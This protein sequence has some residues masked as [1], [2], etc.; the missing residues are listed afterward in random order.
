MPRRVYWFVMVGGL[1]VALYLA[2]CAFFYV[3]QRDL[4]YFPQPASVPGERLQLRSHDGLKLVVSVAGP[5]E[6]SSAVLY[7]GGNA[8]DVSATASGLS[9]ILPGQRIYLMHYRGYGESEGQPTESGLRADAIALFDG[10]RAQHAVLSVAGRSLGS[11]VAVWL[12]T[13]RPVH[14][15]ALITPYDSIEQTAAHHYP[16]LPIAW[17]LKDRFDSAAIAGGITVPT[18][19]L[20]AQQDQVIPPARTEALMAR[21]KPTVVTV[22]RFDGR[23]HGDISLDAKYPGA[24]ARALSP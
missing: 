13:Q 21:F 18:S 19:V 8:E 16:F 11:G 5:V 10:V 4:L 1:L 12:A 24:M 22:T 15:L 17:L 23:N 2:V 7:F 3:K 20:L 9:A 14:R 6:A